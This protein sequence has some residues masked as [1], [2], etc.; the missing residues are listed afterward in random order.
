[1]FN[2]PRDRLAGMGADNI[3][4][5][6]SRLG[7]PLNDIHAKLLLKRFDEN[8][9]GLLNYNDIV[10]FFTPKDKTIKLA[11]DARVSIRNNEIS[12]KI[13]ASSGVHL[14]KLFQKVL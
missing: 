14:R 6:F 8:R 3:K 10:D 4:H 9:D 11:F 12:N 2:P 1:M 5:A 13:S 7:M